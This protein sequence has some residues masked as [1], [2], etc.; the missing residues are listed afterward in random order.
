MKMFAQKTSP[1]PA[2]RL[3]DVLPLVLRE[4][5]TQ[6]RLARQPEP[7]SVMDAV[8]GVA[9]F[10]AAGDDDGLLLPV[11]HFNA[12]A[13]SKL[14]PP[15]GVLLDLGSGSGQFL[16]YLACRRPDVKIIGLELSAEMIRVGREMLRREGLA[17]RVTLR[18]ADMTA[19]PL[20]AL[21]RIDA[22]SCIYALHH[23]PD[24][25]AAQRCLNGV[26]ALHR[27]D[28]CGVWL[29]DH[30]RPRRTDTAERFPEIFTPEAAADFRRDSRNALLASFSFEELSSLCA[31][32]GAERFGHAQSKL[33]KLFQAHWLDRRRNDFAAQANAAWVE[34][35]LPPTMRKKFR[36]LRGL[37][38]KHG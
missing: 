13:V 2:G 38:S 7:A 19:L 33:L 12:L 28:G 25:A 29:F 24:F 3:R 9:S 32:T 30:V 4:G 17:G 31:A 15:N 26:A 8:S 34:A 37:F 6:R 22:I 14:L 11:Y 5:I 35:E 36:Q 16:R 18:Q 10:H 23:L 21:E 27:R 20:E 1:K